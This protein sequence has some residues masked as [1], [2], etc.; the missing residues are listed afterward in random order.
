MGG[1]SYLIPHGWR[2][3]ARYALRR[4]DHGAERSVGD[5]VSNLNEVRGFGL[6]RHRIVHQEPRGVLKA[7]R[8]E[9]TTSSQVA[10]RFA[11][12]SP[13]RFVLAL[14]VNDNEGGTLS[15]ARPL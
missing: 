5:K 3:D 4:V 8:A 13:N 9:C 7:A 10:P 14:V 2:A 12:P 15:S 6:P 11:H 1:S